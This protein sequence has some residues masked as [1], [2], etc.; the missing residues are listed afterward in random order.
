M[1]A[2]ITAMGA[3]CGVYTVG[4]NRT[5]CWWSIPQY[6][7]VINIAARLGLVYRPSVTQVEWTER[8]AALA[9]KYGKPL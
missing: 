3:T 2:L 8:G 1:N 6:E 4:C 7:R 9:R 5:I